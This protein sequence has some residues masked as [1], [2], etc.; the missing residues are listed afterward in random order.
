MLKLTN[1]RVYS[2]TDVLNAYP[3]VIEKCLILSNCWYSKDK[4]KMLDYEKLEFFEKLLKDS[5]SLELLKKII[6]FRE[7][8]KPEYYLTPDLEPQYFPKDIKIF[9]KW[10]SIRFVDGGAYIGDT[11]ESSLQELTK[12][13][14]KIDYIV[15]FE[16]DTSN[17]KKIK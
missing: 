11:L 13:N 15:S 6:N 12:L 7:T 16:P 1:A 9:E 17:I 3:T 10:D 5:K 4:S 2:F 8:L 14:K